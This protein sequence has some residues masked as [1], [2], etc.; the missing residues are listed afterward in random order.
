MEIAAVGEDAATVAAV[1]CPQDIFRPAN[2]AVVAVTIVE[3]D[4]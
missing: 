4:P 1:S 2:N 3:W